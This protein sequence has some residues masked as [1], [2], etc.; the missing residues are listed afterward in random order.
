MPN[1]KP[2]DPAKRSK[3]T[4]ADRRITI[5]ATMRDPIDTEKLAEAL[6]DILPLLTPERRDELAKEGKKIRERL[7]REDSKDTP[8]MV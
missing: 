1:K 6:L 4:A 3:V 8:N 7:E 5:H 2:R